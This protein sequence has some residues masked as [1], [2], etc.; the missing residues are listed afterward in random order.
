MKQQAT[1]QLQ[2]TTVSASD[3]VVNQPTAID[4]FRVFSDQ[5]FYMFVIGFASVLL[6]LSSKTLA[7][8]ISGANDGAGPAA[9][10]V[11]GAKMT[12]SAGMYGAS[13]P[14]GGA[15]GFGGG[16]SGPTMV[17]LAQQTGMG[18]VY[19]HGAVGAT[20]LFRAVAGTAK[21]GAET[22]WNGAEAAYSTGGGKGGG[23]R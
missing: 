19:Q 5:Y 17:R 15:G 16:D 20:N 2:N 12:L 18:G 3:Q 14:A 11:A 1:S 6:H 22:A 9:A 7:S 21:A 13:R 10:V 23:F 8:N 4:A